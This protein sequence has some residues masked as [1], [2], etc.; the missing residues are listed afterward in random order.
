MARRQ[1]AE[2]VNA[3]LQGVFCDLSRGFL[4]VFGKVKAQVLLD[5]SVAAFNIDRVRAFRA[6]M[7]AERRAQDPSEAAPWNLG[8]GRRAASHHRRRDGGSTGLT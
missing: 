7:R 4:R 5:F 1:V 6:R 2:S 3:A 8:A